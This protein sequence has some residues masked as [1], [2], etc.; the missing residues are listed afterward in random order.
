MIKNNLI[1][2]SFWDEQY[3]AYPL[4]VVKKEDLLRQWF[5]SVVPTVIPKGSKRCIEI[6]CYPGRYLAVMGQRGYE[7]NG[8]DLTPGVDDRL[9]LWLREQGCITGSFLREDFLD[10][11]QKES[12][13]LVYS[14]GFIE[15]FIDW[16]AI[17]EQHANLV[18]PGGLLIISV[19]N[20]QGIV[21]RLLH[22]W[23]DNKNL[24]GHNLDSMSPKRWAKIVE[25]R[26]FRIKHAGYTGRF[27]FW[28]GNQSRTPLQNRALSFIARWQRRWVIR[29]I[30][31]GTAAFA[32]YCTMVAQKNHTVNNGRGCL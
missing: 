11:K 14:I 17:L 8:I 1:S 26:G 15:H 13:D 20:F 2:Q 31:Q 19:P 24:Q 18:R 21:Q 5:E 22:R 23:L 27:L 6:G 7:V 10:F 3:L 16:P 9:V 12:F 25:S 29:L 32:P 4:Q 30:P 28:V